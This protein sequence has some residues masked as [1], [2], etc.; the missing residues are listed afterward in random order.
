[1]NL[2][3]NKPLNDYLMLSGIQHFVFCK[4]QCGLIHLEQSW[5]ENTLT[6]QGEALH[7]RVD[8]PE[9]ENRSG[10]RIERALQI[11]S[12]RLGLIGKA[13]LVEFHKYPSATLTG[14]VQENWIPFPVE[15]KRGKPKQ[16][17]ED[18]IQLCAQAMCLEEMFECQIE[19]GSLFYGAEKRRLEVEF[20][21][22]LR[23]ATINAAQGFHNLMERGILPP[24]EFGAKCKNCS[25][26]EE[27]MPDV[28]GINL[29]EYLDNLSPK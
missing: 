15:Y 24:V 16:G 23:E 7:E 20:D 1:M 13:D 12:E 17:L 3:E 26:H 28:Q 8:K 27:C 11:K 14:G 25:L 6:L 5:S 4:R 18:K 19:K 10:I 22:E 9:T 2:K 29:E 21:D